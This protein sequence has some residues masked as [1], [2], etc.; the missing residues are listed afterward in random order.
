[1]LNL[2]VVKLVWL[3]W[4]YLRLKEVLV[5]IGVWKMCFLFI[6]INQDNTS[7]LIPG[8][9]LSKL[10]NVCTIVRGICW[11]GRGAAKESSFYS[12]LLTHTYTK[13]L[14]HQ[15]TTSLPG[16]HCP[17]LFIS[18]PVNK[19]GCVCTGTRSG[20]FSRAS[21]CT[22][23]EW[24]DDR[25]WEIFGDLWRCSGLWADDRRHTLIHIKVYYTSSPPHLQCNDI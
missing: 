8:S 15:H 25:W 4:S 20:F 21:M 6:S 1:M 14:T 24:K 19:Y 9:H 23:C 17:W 13:L 16:H 12:S 10:S 11:T 22:A 5:D 7:K 18:T 2:F 3:P